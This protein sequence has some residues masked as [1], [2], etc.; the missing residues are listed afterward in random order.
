MKS[1]IFYTVL[2]V[3][4]LLPLILISQCPSHLSSI[5]LSLKRPTVQNQ[6][7][8]QFYICDEDNGQMQTVSITGGNTYGYFGIDN[9]GRFFVADAINLNKK[10]TKKYTITITVKDNGYPVK[11]NKTVITLNM[12]K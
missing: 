7:I 12:R 3:I 1:I 9:T 8:H 10:T 5:T 11:R 4:M 2:I 6:T